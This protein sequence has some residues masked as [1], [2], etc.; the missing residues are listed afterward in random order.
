MLALYKENMSKL[1]VKLFY[2]LQSI[3]PIWDKV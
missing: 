2:I 3:I 1:D